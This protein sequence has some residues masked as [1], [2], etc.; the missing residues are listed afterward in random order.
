MTHARTMKIYAYNC[1]GAYIVMGDAIWNRLQK[2]AWPTPRRSKSI[3]VAETVLTLSWTMLF[4][5]VCEHTPSLLQHHRNVCIWW[6]G[7]YIVMDDAI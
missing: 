6:D 2:Y 7:A 3:I 1:D 5:I 4:G